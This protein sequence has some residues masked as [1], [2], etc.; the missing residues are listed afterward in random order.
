[1]IVESSAKVLRGQ[2]TRLL[3]EFEMTPQHGELVAMDIC[4]VIAVRLWERD[5]Y[6]MGILGLFVRTVLLALN[7][8]KMAFPEALEKL[9]HAALTAAL[10]H[11]ALAGCF[12]LRTRRA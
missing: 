5:D 1:M 4:E 6:Q 10:G 9:S 12:D 8:G 2:M 7:K 11:E 3:V